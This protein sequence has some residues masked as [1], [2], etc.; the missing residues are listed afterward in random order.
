MLKLL[1]ITI[2]FLALIGAVGC[3]KVEVVDE[4]QN[5]QN[6]ENDPVVFDQNLSLR[7]AFTILPIDTTMDPQV[8][9]CHRRLKDIIS[10]SPIVNS[11]VVYKFIYDLEK[12]FYNGRIV[13]N[14]SN[15][16]KNFFIDDLIPNLVNSNSS[17]ET[18]IE[19]QGHA[20]RLKGWAF[21]YSGR[22]VDGKFQKNCSVPLGFKYQF[23]NN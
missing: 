15:A 7:V 13:G 18:K 3:G 19:M 16:T 6:E 2:V 14:L 4:Q 20:Q 11:G 21:A 10:R 8:T 23:F 12:L 9:E 17:F 1:K 22:T 5:P